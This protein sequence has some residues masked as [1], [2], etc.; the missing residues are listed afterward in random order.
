M[1]DEDA[2]LRLLKAKKLAELSRRL[3]EKTK[4]KT[5]REI[6]LERLIDRGDEV[7]FKAEQLYPK[8]MGIL[9]EK[10]AE[11]I[12]SGDLDQKITGGQLLQLLRV[13]GLNVPI[14]TKIEFYE[15]GKF[16]SFQ[17]K[18]KKSMGED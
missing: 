16:V 6:V 12:K 18:I 11:F 2:E 13:L 5:P 9:I 4:V 8:E 1:S 10:L 14:E 3:Q 17:E 15:D 7:L